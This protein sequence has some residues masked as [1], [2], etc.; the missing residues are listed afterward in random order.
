MELPVPGDLVW[1]YDTEKLLWQPGYIPFKGW[2]DDEV[3]EGF[4]R[5][6]D[7]RRSPFHHAQNPIVVPLRLVRPRTCDHPGNSPGYH[8]DKPKE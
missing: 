5:V 7:E 2:T 4:M 1:F 3:A 8:V 6:C